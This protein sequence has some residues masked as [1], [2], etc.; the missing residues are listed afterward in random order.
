MECYSTEC[1]V[2]LHLP[3]KNSPSPPCNKMLIRTNIEEF[4][5]SL[6]QSTHRFEATFLL[7]KTGLLS[8]I[9]SRHTSMLESLHNHILMY[10][11][12]RFSFK[13]IYDFYL[14]IA[15][16]TVTVVAC[17]CYLNAMMMSEISDM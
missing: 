5:F 3:H 2:L 17:T 1:Q 10:A 16:I 11:S 6:F 8:F 14:H 13:W 4:S 12:K 7:F 9:L 15:F